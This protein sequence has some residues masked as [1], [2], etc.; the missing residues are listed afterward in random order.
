LA[1]GAD[2]PLC[3]PL[4][5][6]AS[7]HG[8][9]GL[10]GPVFPPTDYRE[11]SIPAIDLMRR[12]ISESAEPITLVP[13]G[14]LTNIALLFSAYPEVKRNIERISLMGGGIS[15]GNWTAAAEFNIFVDPEAAD[16]VFRSGVPIV[17]SPLDVTHKALILPE[18]V[19]A[20]RKTGGKVAGLFADMFDF[21]FKFH[22]GEGFVGAPLHD[23]CAVAYLIA[24][25]LFTTREM[26]I[27]IETRGVHTTGMTLADQRPCPSA[28]P[29]ATVCLDI[30]REGFVKLL[31]EACQFYT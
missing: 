21:Y 17:M 15:T 25:E 31:T 7:V 13:T 27:D 22:R 8:E 30:D 29:N 2:K 14:P 16:I 26:R 3:R 12:V 4:E 24:P 1:A 10:D 9:S 28:K 18:E 5:T 11:E 19:A 23:P 6:A 20:L